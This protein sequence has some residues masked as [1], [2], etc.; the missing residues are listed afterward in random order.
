MSATMLTSCVGVKNTINRSSV[1][2]GE[3]FIKYGIE[4]Y[5]DGV[6]VLKG[7]ECFKTDAEIR[8]FNRQW[9]RQERKER[10]E[11][12]KEKKKFMKEFNRISEEF[13]KNYLKNCCND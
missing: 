5:P 1:N 13:D 9:E 11:K 3:F 6:E 4:G 12:E 8:R 7:S 10:K 2:E